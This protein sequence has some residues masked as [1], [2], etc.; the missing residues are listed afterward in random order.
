MEGALPMTAIWRSLLLAALLVIGWVAPS[1]AFLG[2][3]AA[4]KAEQARQH[5]EQ[6]E[7]EEA[8]KLYRQVQVENPD[9]PLLHFNVGGAL[10]KTGDYEAALREFERALQGDEDR[11]HSPAFYNMGNAFFLQR[12]FE[13]AV[14]A[15][16]NALQADPTDVDA[17]VNLELALE[18]LQQQ[19]QAQERSE[20]TQEQAEQE[21]QESQDQDPPDPQQT[22][23]ARQE[24]QPSGTE[25]GEEERQPPARPREGM[26]AEEA[27]QL[28][29]ALQD[30]EQQAQLRRLRSAG[31]APD[32]DW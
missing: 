25:E 27:E 7:Y 14:E 12:Q 6:G 32:E 18:M 21:E 8:L 22:E 11:L 29:D 24:R 15:Y 4:R 31:M 30:K 2:D 5:Y 17:K 13:Q 16:K 9:S 3:R 1:N 10:F 20:E 23:S 26:T 19:Q 28:L